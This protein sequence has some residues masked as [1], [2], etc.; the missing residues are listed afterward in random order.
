MPIE[1]ITMMGARMF[2][3]K[4][5]GD[6]GE[7]VDVSIDKKAHK[8]CL[9]IALKGEL[10]KLQLHVS[11]ALEK[12]AFVIESFECEREWIA[13]ALNRYVGGKR[14]DISSSVTQTI[15]KYVL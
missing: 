1:A 13:A 12:D 11:Y 7:V 6:L 8:A 10:N 15:L 3:N 9:L 2:L 4:Q 5:F 14:F